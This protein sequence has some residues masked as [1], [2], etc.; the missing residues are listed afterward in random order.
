M[1]VTYNDLKNTFPKEKKSVESIYGIIVPVRK[2][3]YW[4]TI[5]F[6]KI[7]ASA[8]QVSVLSIIIAFLA[9]IFM[10]IPN[11]IIRVIGVIL[12]PIWHLFDCIDGNI[13][14]YTK[15]ESYFG[16]FID[17]MSGY[18]ITIFLPISL[19]CA[20][21]NV[22]YNQLNIS[23][24]YLLIFAGVASTGNALS[25]LIHQKFAF[26]ATQVEIKTGK[27][28]EKGNN[29][30]TLKGFQK[31]RK[32]VGVECG[33]VGIPM[34]ILFLCP[35]FNLYGLLSVYYDLFYILAM[36]IVIFYY[37]WKCNSYNR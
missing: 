6:L 19:A 12:V 33:I 1:K 2:I 11:N 28:I 26:E 17:A 5:P 30:Y 9:C 37:L 24:K 8:F 10:A 21:I 16:E 3:S 34:F 7:G 31:F 32:M 13:A 4:V 23:D 22:G 25:R 36:V 20:S 14:R 27:K 18:I 29:Q 35:F 15:T